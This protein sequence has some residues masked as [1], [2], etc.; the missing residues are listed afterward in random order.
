MRI[1]LTGASSFTG[2]YFAQ[3][4]AQRRHEVIAALSVASIDSYTGVRAERV[5]KLQQFADVHTDAAFGSERFLNILQQSGCD[6]LCH[7]AAEVQNY[8]SPDFDF[9]AATTKNCNN[10]RETL[11]QLKKKGIKALVLTCSVFEAN[12]GIGN[13]PLR[14]FS[15]YGLSK[16][17]TREVF[18]YFC[19][20]NEIPL[21]LFAIPNPF[22]PYEEPRFVNYLVQSWKKK[23]TPTVNTPLYIR[24]NIPVDLLAQAYAA[25]VESS[26]L[27]RIQQ[28]MPHGYIES[29]GE[30]AL[31]VAREFS[32]RVG[33]QY[34]VKLAEQKD[35]SEPMMRINTENAKL[36]SPEWNEKKFWDDYIEYYKKIF[37]S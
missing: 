19:E 34:D 22:G 17:L 2:L 14:A 30:F 33:F 29:Q 8:K 11:Q 9:L 23:E 4:L 25:C 13:E 24:D 37:Y 10:V 21:K 35:F 26:P 15:P 31:R 20:I 36:Q 3:A 5:K 7:H 32:K 28:F 27:F 16:T 18:T 12:M 6:V 1:L